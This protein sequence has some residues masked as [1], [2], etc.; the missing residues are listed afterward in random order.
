MAALAALCRCR[1]RSSTWEPKAWR[2]ADRSLFVL[3]SLWCEGK[4]AKSTS[5]S[6]FP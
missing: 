6:T 5:T 1:P 2:I 4:R 3:P